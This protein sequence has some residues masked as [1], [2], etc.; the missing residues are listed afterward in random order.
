MIYP[1]LGWVAVLGFGVQL[2]EQ[3]SSTWCGCTAGGLFTIYVLVPC[4]RTVHGVLGFIL[5]V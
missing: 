1:L 4:P 5:V 3:G 2:G